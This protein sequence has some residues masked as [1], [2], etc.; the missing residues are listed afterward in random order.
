MESKNNTTAVIVIAF[1]VIII[2]AMICGMIIWLMQR[3]MAMNERLNDRLLD[4]RLQEAKALSAQAA[5]P[6]VEPKAAPVETAELAE[7]RQKLQAAEDAIKR[8]AE[9]R[10]RVESEIATLR[11]S[12]SE[13]TPEPQPAP[14]Q[15]AQP[16]VTP[17][18]TTPQMAQPAVTPQPTP[19]VATATPPA[20]PTPPPAA[21][22]PTTN[23]PNTASGITVKTQPKRLAPTETKEAAKRIGSDGYPINRITLPI[24]NDELD[25]QL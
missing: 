11:Q 19:Q 16:A 24:G 5:A 15:V 9:A 22:A 3:S 2:V 17:Q 10:K 25:W 6:V 7:M 20:Q 14:T 23:K 21:A 13:P 12:K 18:P 4:V 1:S 8:E